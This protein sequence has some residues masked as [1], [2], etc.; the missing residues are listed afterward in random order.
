[1][2]RESHADCDP[3]AFTACY[4]LIG[5]ALLGLLGFASG[6]S[7]HWTWDP[8]GLLAILFLAVFSSTLG[9]VAYTYLLLHE[10]PSRVGTYAYVNPLVAVLA[11]WLLLGER[12]EPLQL[13][14][15]LIVFAGVALVRRLRLWPRQRRGFGPR[16]S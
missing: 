8:A 3:L 7:D 2:I 1:V 13:V 6:D 5:G 10:K 11:G 14:G 12:L 4:L 15:S 16:R 9:F